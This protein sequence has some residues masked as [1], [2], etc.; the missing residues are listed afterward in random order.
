M[1]TV[2]V[3]GAQGATSYWASIVTNPPGHMSHLGA[4]GHEVDGWLLPT[5][6]PPG[7]RKTSAN[8]AP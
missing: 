5:G 1:P 3:P 4:Q 8:Q 2:P 6:G 7:Q